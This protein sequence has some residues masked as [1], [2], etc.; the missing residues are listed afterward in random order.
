M[1]MNQQAYYGNP[2]QQ[3]P[4]GFGGY[5]YDPSNPYLN[6]GFQSQPMY[7][8]NQQMPQMSSSLTD[9][10]IQRLRQERPGSNVLNLSIDPNTVLRSMCNH[11]DKGQDVVQIK[12][13]GSGEVYCPIC[14]NSWSMEE[15]T[16]EELQELVQKLI[17]QMQIAK[18]AGNIPN[19]VLRD[20][21]TIMPLLEK[22]PD[23]WEYSMKN[24]NKMMSANGMYYATDAM[25]YAQYNAMFPGGSMA[26]NVTANPYQQAYYNQP[27]QQQT[28]QFNTPY[29][30]NMNM[31][32][33]PV[34][35]Q[36]ANP[37]V[38]PMQAQGFNQ[39]FNPQFANQQNMMMYNQQ[40]MQPNMYQ[41]PYMN[42]PN[43]GQT[44]QPNFGVAQPQQ[45]AA[46]QQP[47]QQQQAAP[48]TTETKVEL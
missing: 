38:N 35:G 31:G 18:W 5:Y 46:Q 37:A 33:M 41:Q 12:S 10:E 44:Y 28:V 47:T 32:Q 15:M 21:F 22:F 8:N 2:Y 23:L 13:D 30:P 25:P 39:P 17:A 24:F 11:R 3:Q 40:M 1:D 27:M 20:Y 48:V 36:A 26:Y 34:N 9:E 7:F 45:Q 16:K 19:N 43:A 42:Q 6:G 14:G 29:Q 4:F